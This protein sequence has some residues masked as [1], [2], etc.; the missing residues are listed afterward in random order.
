MVLDPFIDS[1]STACAAKSTG[2]NYI[3]YDISQDYIE[4]AEQ[5]IKQLD[6]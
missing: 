6:E 1:G 2:R 5:R 3:G 4:L